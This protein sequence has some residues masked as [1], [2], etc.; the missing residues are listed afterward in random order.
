ML[1]RSPI[2]AL[3][4]RSSIFLSNAKGAAQ[5][6][7]IY[8]ELG[9]FSHLHTLILETFYDPRILAPPRAADSHDSTLKEA[10]INAAIDENLRNPSGM[11]FS[12]INI[13]SD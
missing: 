2:C 8:K 3:I 13:Q 11:S 12:Q 1:L 6:R 9:K 5:E 10:F 7:E 4:Y